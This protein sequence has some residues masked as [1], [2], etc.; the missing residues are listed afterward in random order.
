[1]IFSSALVAAATVLSLASTP[2]AESGGVPHPQGSAGVAAVR[3]AAGSLWA[4]KK[5]KPKGSDDSTDKP[6]RD[7]TSRREE[8]LLKPHNPTPASATTRPRR[9]VKMDAPATADDAADD[10]EDEEADE[11]EEAPRIKR[12]HR[13]AEE[14]EEDEDEDVPLPS[15]PPVLPRLGVLAV[16]ASALGRSFHY[17]TPLQGDSSLARMGYVIS[18]EAFPL[19]RT[20]PGFHRR[21]GLGGTFE[22]QSGT[23]SLLNAS[24]GTTVSYPLS[25]S[26]FGIDLRYFFPIGP[27]VLILPA[28][29]YGRADADL[30]ARTGTL[31][32]GCLVTN[33]RPCVADAAPSYLTA[34]LH[35]RVAVSPVLAFSLVGGYL[36]GVGVAS[37][38]GQ[39][40]SSE[41][42]ATMQGFHVDVGARILIK[43]WFA[44]EAQVPYRRYAYALAPAANSTATYHAAVDSYYGLVA[45]VA[46]LSP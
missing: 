29:G 14:E 44:V 10:S 12:R 24:D 27:H 33:T 26:R 17:D 35:I 28:L 15:L 43:D 13:V 20:P 45:G 38:D 1:M 11:E 31:P 19:H 30:G 42:R 37:G 8:E 5:S 22:H 9:R 21:I 34:D 3:I 25:Q 39:I 7:T 16:G 46:L 36:L 23:A 4:P 40:S 18:L 41:A 2:S 32:S 6:S